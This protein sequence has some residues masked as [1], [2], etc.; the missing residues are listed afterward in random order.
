MSS[1]FPTD[2]RELREFAAVDLSRSFALSWEVHSD[3]LLIDVDVLLTPE[4]PFY[5][6]PRPKEK[7]CIRPAIIEFPFCEGVAS[8][9]VPAE[10]KPASAV[11]R[12]KNGAITGLRQL[13]DGRYEISGEFGAVIIEA[14]RPILRLKNP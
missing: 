11:K 10:T 3:A 4:H 2:W 14:E 8:D 12:L 1:G 13:G 5:E 9:D 6:T 7:V